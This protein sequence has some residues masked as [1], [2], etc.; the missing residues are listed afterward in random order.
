MEAPG[1]ALVH[2]ARV[3]EAHLGLSPSRDDRFR[4]DLFDAESISDPWL[5][6]LTLAA[7]DAPIPVLLGGHS[8]VT[9]GLM[10]LGDVAWTEHDER[11]AATM[12]PV[13]ALP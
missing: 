13:S 4:S 2:D 8:L 3:L 5:R 9:G 6:E 7:A 11:G 1:D 10:A 12:S